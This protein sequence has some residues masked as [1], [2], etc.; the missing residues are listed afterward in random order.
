MII[1][2]RDNNGLPITKIEG[3]KE[4]NGLRAR[5]KG[6]HFGTIPYGT[7]VDL[8]WKIEQLSYNA[9]NKKSYF[10]GVEYYAKDAE[11][12]DYVQFQL[13]DKDNILG[14]GAGY[15]VEEFSNIYVAPNELNHIVLYKA[16]LVPNLYARIKYVSTG[17]TD[18]KFMANMLRHLAENEDE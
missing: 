2:E 14:Y 3:I 1:P 15:M 13:V 17:S 4:P 10:D 7:T 18:V 5:L 16:K 12:G 11:L 9:V 8:D 6:T